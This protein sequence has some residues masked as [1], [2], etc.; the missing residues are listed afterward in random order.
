MKAGRVIIAASG[1]RAVV[2][3]LFPSSAVYPSENQPLVTGNRSG[4]VYFAELEIP[5]NAD[6]RRGRVYYAEIEVPA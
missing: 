4:R 5:A 3:V 2:T 1:R 6:G